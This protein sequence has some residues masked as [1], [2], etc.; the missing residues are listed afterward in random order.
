MGMLLGSARGMWGQPGLRRVFQ[1]SLPIQTLS[2]KHTRWK[3]FQ[4]QN[5]SGSN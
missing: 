2:H 5:L 3:C 4:R 1:A